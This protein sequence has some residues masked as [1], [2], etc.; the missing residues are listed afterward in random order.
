VL[1]GGIDKDADMALVVGPGSAVGAGAVHAVDVGVHAALLIG[2]TPGAGQRRPVR[3][4]TVNAQRLE[5]PAQSHAKQA[6]AFSP[7]PDGKN[8]AAAVGLPGQLLDP[9]VITGDFALAAP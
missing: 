4:A 5:R 9:L 7:E 8:Q 2:Q 6:A 1:R 3:D